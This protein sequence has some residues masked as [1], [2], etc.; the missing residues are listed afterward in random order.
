MPIPA[1]LLSR[2][3]RALTEPWPPITNDAPLSHTSPGAVS[4]TDTMEQ[5]NC[6]G[7]VAQLTVTAQDRGRIEKSTYESRPCPDQGG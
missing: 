1:A 6:Q 3:R 4:H 7:N 2:R 5:D